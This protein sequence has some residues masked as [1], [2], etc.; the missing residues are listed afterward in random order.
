MVLIGVGIVAYVAADQAITAYN[1]AFVPKAPHAAELT[2]IV[3]GRYTVTPM[4]EDVASG[5]MQALSIGR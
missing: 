1:N 5:K 2:G 3:P 4:L